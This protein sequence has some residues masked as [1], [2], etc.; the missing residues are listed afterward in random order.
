MH[1]DK[2]QIIEC[3]EK[4]FPIFSGMSEGI[5]HGVSRR[6]PE[7]MRKE[8][9]KSKSS[10]FEELLKTWQVLYG[11]CLSGMTAVDCI[12]RMDFNR[13]HEVGSKEDD[14]V[15]GGFDKGTC[16]ALAA[17]LKRNR[18]IC[19]NQ[20]YQGTEMNCNVWLE[21]LSADCPTCAKEFLITENEEK[22]FNWLDGDRASMKDVS[23]CEEMADQKKRDN[24]F[25]RAA[26]VLKNAN[27]CAQVSE[28]AE[29]PEMPSATR[30]RRD[31]CYSMCALV[32]QE[33]TSGVIK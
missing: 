13:C 6:I 14:G 18:T 31:S 29:F 20:F 2:S 9:E 15:I 19:E 5:W 10:W 17:F 30:T 1:Q 25:S 11:Q 21:A 3:L 7:N 26:I 16:Y 23:F 8:F 27:Y 12:D 4:G 22:Y 33:K 28:E 32:S 24:C